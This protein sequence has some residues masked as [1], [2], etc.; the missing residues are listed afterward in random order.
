[1]LQP[2]ERLTITEESDLVVFG[3]G[4][5]QDTIPITWGQ[6]VIVRVASERLTLVT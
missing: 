6:Q 1:M 3:D 2:D 5:E 4:I